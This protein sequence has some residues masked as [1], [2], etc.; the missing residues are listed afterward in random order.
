MPHQFRNGLPSQYCL[1]QATPF[2]SA[3]FHGSVTS[4]FPSSDLSCSLCSPWGEDLRHALREFGFVGALETLQDGFHYCGRWPSRPSQFLL[5]VR[6]EKVS[7]GGQSSVEICHLAS[8][9]VLKTALGV[10]EAG[11][12]VQAGL[13][14]ALMR[15]TQ[16][17]LVD[18][19]TLLG[20][21]LTEPLHVRP[22]DLLEISI[23]ERGVK[24]RQRENNV[25]RLSPVDSL[26][27]VRCIRIS[28]G[29]S[30]VI[31]AALDMKIVPLRGIILEGIHGQYACPSG[32]EMYDKKQSLAVVRGWLRERSTQVYS[33]WPQ[34]PFSLG[35]LGNR[36][37]GT[38]EQVLSRWS[39]ERLKW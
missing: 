12:P 3:A 35:M 8:G 30:D 16:G 17:R 15:I 32:G 10:L 1:R 24:V 25:I 29:P 28:V 2:S 11:T 27:G 18:A 14:L 34:R 6:A 36:V 9:N 22:S 5:S 33:A 26:Q 39:E 4:P 7:N 20:D 37:L 38:L 21:S 31:G 23:E 19:A 13:V